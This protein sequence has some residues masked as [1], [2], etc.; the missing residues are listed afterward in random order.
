[1]KTRATR[2]TKKRTVKPA[3][4]TT[5]RKVKVDIKSSAAAAV[6]KNKSAHWSTFKDLEKKA[7]KA[8]AKLRS[9]VKRKASPATLLKDKNALLLLLGE[10]NYMARQC[11]RAAGAQKKSSKKRS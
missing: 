2:K 3:K 1:M 11:M 7:E 9:D 5:K 10:C 6:K 8:L 4:K